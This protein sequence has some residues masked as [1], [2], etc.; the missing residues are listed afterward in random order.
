MFGMSVVP[1]VKKPFTCLRIGQRGAEARWVSNHVFIA[2]HSYVSPSSL[3]F[4]MTGSR[5]IHFVIGQISG[6][7][8]VGEDSFVGSGRDFFV[9]VGTA[10]VFRG[11]P[12]FLLIS[13]GWP[14]VGRILLDWIPQATALRT[15]GMGS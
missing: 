9:I 5:N 15:E 2:S 3:P 13:G 7:G 1:S 10:G 8:S 4:I 6:S 11:L 14:F 12:L